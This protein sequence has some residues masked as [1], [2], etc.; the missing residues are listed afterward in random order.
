M[1]RSRGTAEK[2]ILL[3]LARVFSLFPPFPQ[4]HSIKWSILQ[5]KDRAESSRRAVIDA[6]EP[7]VIKSQQPRKQQPGPQG[8]DTQE[9]Y[10]PEKVPGISYRAKE[11]QQPEHKKIYPEERT[12]V[13]HVMTDQ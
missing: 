2:R 11:K 13:A 9:G 1:V 12:I 6:I 3:D 4:H 5:P 7:K 8:K 10:E